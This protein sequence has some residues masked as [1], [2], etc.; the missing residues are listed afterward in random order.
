MNLY[1]DSRKNHLPAA[2][3]QERQTAFEVEVLTLK[4]NLDALNAAFDPLKIKLD[5]TAPDLSGLIEHYQESRGAKSI[6][7]S[8]GLLATLTI[9]ELT[10]VQKQTAD[11]GKILNESITK[12]L[13]YI[14]IKYPDIG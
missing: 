2:T 10:K 4:K 1:V 6:T 14:K 7:V 11:N 8:N 5:I 3:Q 13:A 9:Q 12:L